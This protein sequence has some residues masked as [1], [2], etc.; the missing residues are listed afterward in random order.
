MD[1]FNYF[2]D[3]N[4]KPTA[5]QSTTFAKGRFFTSPDKKMYQDTLKTIIAIQ[6][7]K[8]GYGI[9][10][11]DVAVNV[12]VIALFKQPKTIK[13]RFMTVKPD[14]DNLRKPI[15]DALQGTILSADQQVVRGE[16]FKL[17]YKR[18]ALLIKVS[19]FNINQVPLYVNNWMDKDDFVDYSDMFGE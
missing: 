15:L 5:K 12:E 8:K 6:S 16:T 19:P 10:P 2:F 11:K 17:Y 4:I 13:R 9:I 3:I 18:D 7:R 1:S 14:E